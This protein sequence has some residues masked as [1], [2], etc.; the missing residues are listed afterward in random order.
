MGKDELDGQ[1]WLCRSDTDRERMLDM[2]RRLAPVR[3]RAFVVLAVVLLASAPWIGYWT[4]IP[5]LIAAAVFKTADS[6]IASVA[7]PEWAMFAAWAASEAIIAASILLTGG[8]TEAM[9]AWLAIP[10]VTLS[11]RFST[12][13]IALGVAIA[14]GLLAIVGLTSDATG[15]I[16]NPPLL[17]AP[18]GLIVA[19]AMLSTALMHSDVEHRSEAVIDQLTGMLNRHALAGR[20]SEL[21]QQ[22]EVTGQPV[23]IILG[24]VDHF[25]Q[26]NDSYGHPIG[27][28]VLKDIAYRMRKLLRA[29][30]LAYRL[31]GEEFLVL[32]PGADQQESAALA[33]Q[34]RQAVAE[35]TAAG[36]SVTMSFGVSASIQGST[37]EFP[38]VLAEADDALYE[39]KRSGRDRVCRATSRSRRTGPTLNPAHVAVVTA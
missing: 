21:A 37:F 6:R 15:I 10:I 23:G 32:L 5:L 38:V 29:F 18:A 13:G 14:L 19:V 33:E 25:K 26:V 9:L 36:Q 7:R 28:A 8:S 4:I 16:A 2:D 11:A 20:T 30:D 17:L 35:T 12:R 3:R 31:G 22:S 34:L 1:S 39:A 27:D 24:D